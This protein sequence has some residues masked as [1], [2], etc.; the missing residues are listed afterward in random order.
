M[1][2]KSFQV[3]RFRPLIDPMFPVS[4]PPGPPS[5]SAIGRIRAEDDEVMR[6][7]LQGTRRELGVETA[8]QVWSKEELDSLSRFFSRPGHAY[9]VARST[10]R[11]LGGVGLAPWNGSSKACELRGLYVDRDARGRGWGTQLV[12]RCLEEARSLGYRDCLVRTR[13][14]MESARKLYERLDFELID[15]PHEGQ[16][17]YIY[18]RQLDAPHGSGHRASS[19]FN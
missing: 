15:R 6:E 11:V 7:I 18:R 10:D 2:R 19:T 1:A 5:D 16:P 4:P 3:V 14:Q 13:E 17:Q 12:E 8:A 9:F